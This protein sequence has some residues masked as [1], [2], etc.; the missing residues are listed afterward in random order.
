[1]LTGENQENTEVYQLLIQGLDSL[2]S[3]H[4]L[5]KANLLATF[6][7]ILQS[8]GFVGNNPLS[9]LNLKTQIEAIADKKLHSKDFLVPGKIKL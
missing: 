8:L 4:G 2:S 6:Q 1:M 9:E 3:P 5:T 7:A